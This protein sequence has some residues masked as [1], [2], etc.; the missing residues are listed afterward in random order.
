MAVRGRRRDRDRHGRARLYLWPIGASDDAKPEPD[1]GG[2]ERP[3]ILDANGD[4]LLITSGAAAA[5]DEVHA[6]LD[7]IFESAVGGTS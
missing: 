2:V 4:R 1:P 6:E 3:W 7:A 5:A